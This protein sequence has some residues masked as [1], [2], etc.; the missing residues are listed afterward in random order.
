MPL[1]LLGGCASLDREPF[2]AAQL[3]AAQLPE[4][5][6][7]RYWA[8]A[9]DL[10][11]QMAIPAPPKGEPLRL[12]ALSGGGDKGAYGAGFLNGWSQSGERP[13]FSLV[14]GVSTGALIAPFALLGPQYD[15]EL[16]AAYTQITPDDVYQ[17]R[18]AL[19]IPF[20]SSAATTG[21]LEQLIA[22]FATNA[23]IDA[24]ALQHR[25]GR[26]LYVGTVSLDRPGNAIWDMGAIAASAAPDRY[27]LFRRIM[28][29][30]SSVPVAFPPVL[31]ET[32]IEG[33]AISE[34]HVDG[35][36]IATVLAT[37]SIADGQ[38][39]KA[40]PQA[41]LYLLVNGK[42]AGEFEMIN[43]S[44]PDLA[45]RT[46]DVIL[47]ASLQDR[48]DS[49]YVWAQTVGA[50]YRLTY[51]GQDYD[52]GD[53]DLFDQDF[54]RELYAYGLERGSQAAWQ[55]R[56]PSTAPEPEARAEAADAD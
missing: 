32:R 40:G 27:D 1:L 50:T 28:L 38:T 47:F 49:A 6:R 31:I 11:E 52:V 16:T 33:R 5:P 17:P 45:A 56:P 14:T 19:A 22:R 39:G 55:D 37:P 24:V 13:Q 48:V 43:G 46:I 12:L 51:I 15:D 21:P 9:P 44:L 53:H 36:T 26:R 7:V 10:I 30:S 35:G 29:A 18:F 42:M 23:V 41:E 54:M 25:L 3:E 34:L 20:S 2:T 8:D 4:M